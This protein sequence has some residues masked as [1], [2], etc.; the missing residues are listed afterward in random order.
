[1]RKNPEP[2]DLS[3]I[4]NAGNIVPSFESEFNAVVATVEYAVAAPFHD[5]VATQPIRAPLSHR[6]H[7][8]TLSTTKRVRRG[9]K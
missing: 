4:R 5:P 3:V 9:S 7:H 8:L 1:M 6:R 2:R